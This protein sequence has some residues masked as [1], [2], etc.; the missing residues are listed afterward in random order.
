VK[1]AFIGA[2]GFLRR[3]FVLIIEDEQK[4]VVFGLLNTLALEI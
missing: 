2:V 3:T 4:F 1:I